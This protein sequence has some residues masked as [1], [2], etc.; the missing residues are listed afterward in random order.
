M[1]LTEKIRKFLMEW[2]LAPKAIRVACYLLSRIVRPR[3]SIRLHS[4]ESDTLYL[5]ANGPSLVEDLNRYEQEITSADRLVVNFMALDA[6]FSRLKPNIYLL[7][8]PAY[9]ISAEKLSDGLRTRM[10]RLQNIIANEVSWPMTLMVPHS[11][12][13]SEVV[14][15]VSSHKD[16]KV[17]HFWSGVP[18]PENIHDFRGWFAN[19]YAA[20]GQTVMNTA[21]YIGILLKYSHIVLLGA[22]TS[23]HAMIHVEQDTNRLYINDEH[24]YGV[25]KRYMFVDAGQKVPDRMSRQ[26]RSVAT[27]FA[28]YDK[29]REFADWA[30]V[31]IVNASS[32]S[33]IDAFERPAKE[34]ILPQRMTSLERN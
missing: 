18:C 28:W 22:D 30:G 4:R 1:T 21:V 5:L 14:R 31:R 11:A 27:A 29:L 8:D 12:L 20:P 25:E 9:F 33:W 7:A 34:N 19:R 10:A 23:F 15:Y 17:L 2:I 3:T 6:R 32:F 24:F 26:L 16:I 13:D